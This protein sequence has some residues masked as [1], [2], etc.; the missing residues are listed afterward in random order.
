MQGQLSGFHLAL[1]E[2]VAND[3]QQAMRIGHDSVRRPHLF[4]VDRPVDGLLDH[5]GIPQ[6]GIERGAQFM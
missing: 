6:N 1:V 5:L 2:Q 4:L 3:I